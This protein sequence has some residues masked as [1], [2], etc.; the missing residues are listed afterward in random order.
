MP[1][2]DATVAVLAVTR[3][4]RGNDWLPAS[5]RARLTVEGRLHDLHA[6]DEVDVIGRLYAPPPPG[7]PGEPDHASDLRDRRIRAVVVVRKTADGVVRLGDGWPRSVRGWLAMLRG[8]CRR[9]LEEAI[10]EGKER[11][12]AIALLLGDGSALPAAEWDKYKRTGVVHVLVVSGQQLTV[13]GWFLWF[14]LRRLGLRGRTGAVVVALVLLVYA[15]M[16]GGAPPAMR[17]AVLAAS[18]CGGLL[19]RRPVLTANT[20][21]LA[22]LVVGL[23]NPT[24][25]CTTGCQLSF[26]CVAIIYWCAN[27][28]SR[29][30]DD[31]LNRL[32]E[33]SRPPWQRH[34]LAV[35]RRVGAAY[36]LSLGI[37]LAA[38]PLVATRYNTV[39]PLAVLLML[40]LV[41]LA[42]VALVAG[43]LLLLAAPLCWPLALALGWVTRWCLAICDSL[44][45]LGDGVPGGHWYVGRVPEWW[46]WVFYVALLSVVMLVSLRRHVRWFA[47]AGLAWLCVGL[48]G[49]AA[50]RSS[51]ELRC[52]FLAVG[53]G[54]CIVIETPDG[55]TLLYDAGAMNGPEVTE[56]HVAP[57]LWHRGIKRVDEVFISHAHLDHYSG[58]TALLDRFA[59]GQVT[60][61]PS[62]L[63]QRQKVRGVDVTL[64]ALERRRVPVRAV[65]AGDRLS[66]GAVDIDVLHAPAEDVGDNED[67]RSLVL[68]VRHAGHSLLLTG[69]LRA[70]GQDY[71]LSL[72]PTP[73]DVLQ[74]P[75]HG[76]AAANTEALAKWARPKVVVS[77]Q[78]VPRTA[79]DVAKPYRRIGA[80]FLPTWPHGAVTVR[81]HA[82]GLVVETYRSGERIVVR[83]AARE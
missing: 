35:A 18:V 55:R 67:E 82:T 71:L 61:T 69:D 78:G 3:W 68:L 9:V 39:S 51:D 81:S 34:A 57:F 10:P 44:V 25:W 37:W 74:S 56:R 54:G 75:H 73:V 64:A 63:R 6:G 46:L 72:P 60:V 65:N 31:P 17:A 8:H 43:F 26:L 28:R 40:P 16:V 12:L 22:W 4:R 29:A 30:E 15:L 47:L 38:A 77:C 27:R 58:V 52:T 59:V 62:F 13:L 80:E 83:G 48:V 1:Q 42:A 53:H 21:A 36:A 14:V 45:D 50:P 66:A 76:S 79:A 2:G 5:G 70:A 7:N 41:I 20:F 24:D 11:G 23:I 19:F 32:V 49:G 33:E